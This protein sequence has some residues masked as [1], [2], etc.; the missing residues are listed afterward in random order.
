[1]FDIHMCVTHISINLMLDLH[2]FVNGV[3]EVVLVVCCESLFLVWVLVFRGCPVLYDLVAEAGIRFHFM[4][5]GGLLLV[6]RA[7]CCK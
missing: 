5:H 7:V 4:S 1:M 6:D 2:I 3:Y